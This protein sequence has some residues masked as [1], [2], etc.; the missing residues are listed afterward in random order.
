LVLELKELKSGF[1]GVEVRVW[2]CG[3]ENVRV[4]K[5]KEV[6]ERDSDNKILFFGPES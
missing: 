2:D 1:E 3:F 5:L 4:N 6:K